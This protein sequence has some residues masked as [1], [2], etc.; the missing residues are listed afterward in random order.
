MYANTQ[1]YFF[2][3]KVQGKRVFSMH[4]LFGLKKI[5]V[6]VQTCESEKKNAK[7]KISFWET[8]F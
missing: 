1:E 8:D 5:P 3:D 7:I 4:C 2:F 6:G